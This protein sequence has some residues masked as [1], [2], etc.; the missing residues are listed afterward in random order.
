MT[1]TYSVE[2]D[3]STVWT[4]TKDAYE[5]PGVFPREYFNRPKDTPL[6]EAH[7]SPAHL[8]LTSSE[9]SDDPDGPK[10]G[11]PVLIG[12]QRAHGDEA[13]Q[14]LTQAA[15]MYAAGDVVPAIV[16][17]LDADAARVRY[18]EQLGDTIGAKK[19]RQE[20]IE[21][22]LTLLGIHDA[23]VMEVL[24]LRNDPELVS[25]IVAALKAKD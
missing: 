4:E 2:V 24:T 5:G 14:L 6:D 25:A 9:D 12:I 19:A 21:E 10:A 7:P 8:Y 18:L 17:R 20:R 13:D 16:S 11:E 23:A 1:V 15:W 22:F 3:G